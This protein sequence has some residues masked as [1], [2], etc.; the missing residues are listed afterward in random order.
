MTATRGAFSHLIAP[1]F[2]KIVF[3]SY[4]EK[5]VEGNKLVNMGTMNRAYIDDA[6]LAGFG[7]LLEKPEG[8]RVIYQDPLDGRT[9]RYVATT[10]GLGFRITEEM[11]EDDL[12]GIVG[13]KLSRALGRSVRNNFEVVAHSILNSGFDTTVNGF[14]SGVSLFST[15]HTNI[16]G[17]T[18][19]NR[20][21]TD[22]DLSLASL[23]AAVEAFH[24]WTD[25][26]GLPVAA[27][28]DLLVVGVG[29]MW[30][31]G[32]ILGSQQV[33]GSNFNDPNIVA[34]LGLRLHVSHYITDPDAW[35]LIDSTSHDMNYFDRR[36]PR[37]S[38]TDD[39]DSG[40]AKFKVT[41]RNAAG[42]GDW[43]FTYGT[44]GA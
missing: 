30:T 39:F 23:Q 7:T 38:N 33:P 32:V 41:R 27:A 10:Y 37:F 22:A 8:G 1:G 14:E 29:N 25:E 44:Q 18:Q 13:N 17:G 19:A 4:K 31:A 9:K 12:Y 2:R 40:D 11:M 42:F 15:A 21:G 34:K 28:P 26:M 35:F 3:E 43:R 6:N 16:G 24:G 36:A 20:P 5:P